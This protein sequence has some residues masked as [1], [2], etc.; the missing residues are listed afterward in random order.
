MRLGLGLTCFLST[1]LAVLNVYIYIY[2]HPVITP[3][4]TILQF[5]NNNNNNNSQ[6][7]NP[8]AITDK[9]M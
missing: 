7:H 8:Q 5:Y 9:Y 4:P 2:I 6:Q 3:A 1:C